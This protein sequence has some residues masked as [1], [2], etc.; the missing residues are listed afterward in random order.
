[1][2][3]LKYLPGKQVKSAYCDQQHQRAQKML[4][5]NG[6]QPGELRDEG[7]ICRPDAEF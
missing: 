6:V 2:C 7:E 5:R 4:M 1:V 3:A